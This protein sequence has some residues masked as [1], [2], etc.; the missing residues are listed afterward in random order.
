[1]Q[2]LSAGED[3]GDIIYSLLFLQN[4]FFSQPTQI[5]RHYFVYKTL[6]LRSPWSDHSHQDCVTSKKCQSIPRPQRNV[7]CCPRVHN[8]SRTFLKIAIQLSCAFLA[9]YIKVAYLPFDNMVWGGAG[10]ILTS[11]DHKQTKI[12]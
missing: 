5:L 10:P 9:N 7:M 12:T 1:M 8:Y 11:L 6:L 4:V 2:F 3:A